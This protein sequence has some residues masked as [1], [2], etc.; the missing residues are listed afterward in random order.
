MNREKETWDE[1]VKDAADKMD[2]ENNPKLQDLP[3]KALRAL[4][5]SLAAH[6]LW[7]LDQ[8]K[9]PGIMHKALQHG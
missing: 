6:I 2:L 9:E 4:G 5:E 8:M 7:D 3:P 1:K